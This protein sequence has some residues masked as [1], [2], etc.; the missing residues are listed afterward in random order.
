MPDLAFPMRNHPH[1]ET[2]REA[3]FPDIADHWQAG[4]L[5][6]VPH[7][8]TP[9]ETAKA[10]QAIKSR[11]CE[12]YQFMRSEEHFPLGS[13]LRNDIRRMWERFGK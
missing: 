9:W 6:A 13:T 4:T 1:L 3:G 8:D 5:P 7:I 12:A 2:L 11:L 10:E